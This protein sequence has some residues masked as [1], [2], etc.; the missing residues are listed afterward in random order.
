MCLLHCMRVQLQ[1]GYAWASNVNNANPHKAVTRRLEAKK[2][3]S[4][5]TTPQLHCG[6]DILIISL[7]QVTASSPHFKFKWLYLSCDTAVQLTSHEF[8]VRQRNINYISP[9]SHRIIAAFQVQMNLTFM[10]RAVQLTSHE[11]AVRQRNKNAVWYERTFTILSKAIGLKWH[12]S[13]WVHV[14]ELKWPY[15]NNLTSLWSC[16][17]NQ[18]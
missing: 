8:A 18:Y 2:L 3:R 5:H 4:I 6:A 11:L 1:N 17:P 7:L 13:C 14:M 9:A 15:N 10:R 16:N 12:C